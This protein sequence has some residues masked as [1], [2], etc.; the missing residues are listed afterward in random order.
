MED[1]LTD[2]VADWDRACCGVEVKALKNLV[3]LHM[4]IPD[5]REYGCK[6]DGFGVLYKLLLY[7][8]RLIDDPP[9]SGM[10]CDTATVPYHP[11]CP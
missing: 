5:A 7:E 6:T 9:S 2:E 1:L 10:L 11:K 4:S 3:W 8:R